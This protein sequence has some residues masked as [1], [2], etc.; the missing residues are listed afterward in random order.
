VV[1]DN[2]VTF[3]FDEL[4][5]TQ[6]GDSL[7]TIKERAR[8]QVPIFKESEFATY[9]ATRGMR[10]YTGEPVTIPNPETLAFS[11]VS[12]TT[13]VTDIAPLTSLT[14]MLKGDARI[15]WIFD[16]KKLKE[17]LRSVNKKDST[18]VFNRY[19]SSISNAEVILRPFWETSLPDD[20][21]DI[22]LQIRIGEEAK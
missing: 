20:A 13:T 5:S 12:A 19:A 10:E 2:S 11:Y 6:Y 21:E 3:A 4:P 7:A 14:F 16:E 9:I 17:E 22:L 15:V 18:V 1:Y 8:L